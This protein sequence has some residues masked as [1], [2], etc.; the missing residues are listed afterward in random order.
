MVYGAILYHKDRKAGGGISAYSSPI[1]NIP[2]E[3]ETTRYQGTPIPRPEFVDLEDGQGHGFRK[4][5][6]YGVPTKDTTYK[7]ETQNL[8]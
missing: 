3:P 6:S 4:T 5:G 1:Y 7:G 2:T 8:M